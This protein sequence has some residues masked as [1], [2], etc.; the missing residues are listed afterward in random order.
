MICATWDT[1]LHSLPALASLPWLLG[2]QLFV[3]L[4][5]MG[6]YV[7]NVLSTLST[8]LE[9]SKPIVAMINQLKWNA[10][11]HVL[12]QGNNAAK[13]CKCTNPIMMLL[14]PTNC[15]KINK[16]AKKHG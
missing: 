14:D 13:T 10:E 11:E 4:S 16:I 3:K 15:I 2:G 9:Q 1:I 7:S 8:W 6:W 5:N 12:Q